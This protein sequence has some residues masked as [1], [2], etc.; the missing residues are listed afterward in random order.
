MSAVLHSIITS[1][2]N[3]RIKNIIYIWKSKKNIQENI[4]KINE[5]IKIFK[6]FTPK[7]SL[8][9]QQMNKI[10]CYGFCWGRG[11]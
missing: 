8:F 10:K 11:W 1:I 7:V 2:E 4:D 5:S 6:F 3:D 9:V